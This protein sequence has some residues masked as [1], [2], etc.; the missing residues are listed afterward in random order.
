[1]WFLIVRNPES[2]S[3][4]VPRHRADLPAG[5]GANELRADDP[6]GLERDVVGR[7]TLLVR[8]ETVTD[9]SEGFRDVRDLNL[10]DARQLA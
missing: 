1:L 6:P 4:V 9:I 3:L 2:W 7:A 10:L 5:G 8:A